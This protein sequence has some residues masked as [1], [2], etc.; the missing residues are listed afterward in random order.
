[1]FRPSELGS[2]TVFGW[3]DG[4][5][6]EALL[7]LTGRNLFTKVEG[8]FE[9]VATVWTDVRTLSH[10]AVTLHISWVMLNCPDRSE[11]LSLRFEGSITSDLESA[12]P[13]TRECF[14][15]IAEDGTLMIWY[16]Q[17]GRTR[18]RRFPATT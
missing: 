7:D 5:S 18:R 15:T 17:A 9:R 11:Q 2:P 1:M 10:E 6:R 3:L 14:G 8:P 13:S 4:M 16:K 12:A